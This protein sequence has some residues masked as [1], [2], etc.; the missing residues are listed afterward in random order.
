[1][2]L[3]KI[4]DTANLSQ[5]NSISLMMFKV[6]S[7]DSED[8]QSHP[9]F[10]INI[11][12]VKEVLKVGDYKKK[13]MPKSEED[14]GIDGFF[15]GLIEVRK[16]YIPVFDCAKWLGYE[17]CVNEKSV[18]I[19]SE[20]NHKLVGLQVDYIHDVSEVAWTDIKEST[21]TDKAVSETTVEGEL[22]LIIDIEKMLAQTSGIDLIEESKT[23]T[24]INTDKEVIFADDSKPIREYM[25]AL[26][27][28]LNVK[29]HIFTDGEGLLNYLEKGQGKGVGLILT[30]LEMPN[31]S[32]HT[33]IKK[34]KA[35]EFAKHI[36]V[37]V[38]SSMT[39]GDSKRQAKELGADDFIGKI[40]TDLVVE[41]LKKYLG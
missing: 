38:H 20:V 31:V 13:V 6:T 11:F 15:M 25:A 26:F 10:G 12:K 16:A 4:N 29:S 18:I 37:V 28:N 8:F 24:S 1:M 27:K 30:D 3:K 40:D 23:D 36:P 5:N 7:A 17:P 14:D 34:A 32:G 39:V 2:D 33:V 21:A 22:C 41:M 9:F 19:V 35:M